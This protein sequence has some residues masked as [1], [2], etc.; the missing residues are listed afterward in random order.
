MSEVLHN[1]WF[2]MLDN[3]DGSAR[4]VFFTDQQEAEKYLETQEILNAESV[5]M[6]DSEVSR[7]RSFDT[8]QEALENE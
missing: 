3:G 6:N 2:I 5:W 1:L 7:V 8:C 4:A